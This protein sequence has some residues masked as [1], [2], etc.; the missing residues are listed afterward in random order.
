[1]VIKYSIIKIS[2]LKK[3][4]CGGASRCTKGCQSFHRVYSL[5]FDA[6][7]IDLWAACPS[8]LRIMLKIGLIASLFALSP[9]WAKSGK[10]YPKKCAKLMQL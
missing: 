7:E 3:R 6:V 9:F 10:Y 4:R 1:M 5:L 8:R 2:K